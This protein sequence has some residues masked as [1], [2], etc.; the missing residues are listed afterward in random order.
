M[1]VTVTTVVS[2]QWAKVE[3]KYAVTAIGV[4]ALVGLWT[5]IGAIKVYDATHMLPCI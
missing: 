2:R 4:A 1:C 3:D 5:A